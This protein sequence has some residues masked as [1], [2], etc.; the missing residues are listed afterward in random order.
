M[1]NTNKSDKRKV[2]FVHGGVDAEEREQIREITDSLVGSEMCIRDRYSTEPWACT[3]LYKIRV[4]PLR[5]SAKFVINLFLCSCD[6]KYS[7]SSL[8]VSNFC[9]GCLRTKH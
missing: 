5:S 7:I 2:F 3:L 8:Y 6:I 4:L 1:I 9:G